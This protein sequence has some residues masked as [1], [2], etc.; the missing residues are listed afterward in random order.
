MKKTNNDIFT[1]TTIRTDFYKKSNKPI[2]ILVLDILF[3]MN[4]Y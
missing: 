4:E 3:V 1:S 2:H